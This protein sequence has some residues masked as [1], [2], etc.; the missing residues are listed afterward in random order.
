MP[1]LTPKAITKKRV[2][3]KTFYILAGPNGAGK[4]TLSKV[5]LQDVF[6]CENFVNADEIAKGLS[7]LQANK[8]DIQAGK[9]MLKQIDHYVKNKESFCVETTLSTKIYLTKIQKLRQLGYKIFLFF[10]YLPNP[11]LAIKRVKQRV[12]QGGHDIPVDTIKRRYRRGLENLVN[13]YFNVVDNLYIYSNI[14]NLEKIACRSKDGLKV[15]NS[16]V[17]KQIKKYKKSA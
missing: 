11:E 16:E 6:A 14:D 12:S 17:F 8:F 9:I 15:Q 13:D 7:P 10:I 5:V 3:K 2:H 1:K 4:T